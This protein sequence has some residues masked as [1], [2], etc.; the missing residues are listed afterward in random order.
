MHTPL[1]RD[2]DRCYSI[3]T[4]PATD[5]S[6]FCDLARSFTEAGENQGTAFSANKGISWLQSLS[7]CRFRQAATAL[8][9][10]LCAI[11]NSLYFFPPPLSLTPVRWR[12]A[13]LLAQE[14]QMITSSLKHGDKHAILLK[15]SAMT[16]FTNG[17]CHRML[18]WTFKYHS[19]QIKICIILLVYHIWV[20][21]TIRARGNTLHYIYVATL[22]YKKHFSSSSQKFLLWSAKVSIILEAKI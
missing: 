2:T 15:T 13:G 12:A 11:R 21:H 20:I 22:H 8:R 6:F 3:S 10:P 19:S 16:F 14:N 17:L 1:H 9:G 4:S 18:K 7:L 5:G